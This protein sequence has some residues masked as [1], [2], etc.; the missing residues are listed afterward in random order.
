MFIQ[1]VEGVA[2]DYASELWYEQIDK[3]RVRASMGGVIWLQTSCFHNVTNYI[4]F[5]RF[6]GEDFGPTL[7]F[8]V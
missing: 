5:L 8:L 6:G 3:A 2:R 7:E 1:S 4:S